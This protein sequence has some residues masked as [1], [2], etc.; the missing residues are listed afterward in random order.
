MKLWHVALLSLMIP[1]S[2]SAQS[3]PLSAHA[4]YLQQGMKMIVLQSVERMPESQYAFRPTPAVRTYREILGHIADMQYMY[5][6]AVLGE[7]NPAAKIEGVKTTK[8]ELLAAINGSFAYCDRAFNELTDANASD[9][10]TFMGTQPPR[11]SLLG[12]G[13]LH[14]ILHYGNLITYMRMNNIVPPTSDPELMPQMSK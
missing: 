14:G 12:V 6:A 3:N 9:P 13:Q 8:A 5:C 4:R 10:V 1:A 2:S 7:R 11:I